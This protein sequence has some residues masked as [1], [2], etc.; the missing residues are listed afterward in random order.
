MERA[1]RKATGFRPDFVNDPAFLVD[2]SRAYA[3]AGDYAPAVAVL[4]E[5]SRQ[6]PSVRL[7]YESLKRLYAAHTGGETQPRY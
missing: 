2:L 1:H 7:A 5:L 4:F 6:Y 3:E